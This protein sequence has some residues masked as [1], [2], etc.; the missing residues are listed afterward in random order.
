MTGRSNSQPRQN[1]FGRSHRSR[2]VAIAEF[3]LILPLILML[4][5]GALDLGLLTQARLIVANVCREGGSVGS[6]TVA[7]DNSIAAMMVS[8]G[9][10]LNLGGADGKIYVTRI[11]AGKDKN[12][13]NPTAQAPITAGGLS[14]A[15]KVAG[16]TFGLSGT[17]YNHLKFIPGNNAPDIPMVTIV[18]VYYKYHPV[19]GVSKVLLPGLFTS[20]NG[21][22]VIWSKAVF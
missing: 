12:N 17:I 18:E 20:D 1:R 10:P 7:L 4:L 21:G 2:G 11:L 14:Y 5:L 3:V 19:T 9:Q 22:L 6:R 13:V 8:S 16:G 15:S